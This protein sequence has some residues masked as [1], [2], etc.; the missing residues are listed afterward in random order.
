VSTPLQT[1][2]ICP[3]LVGRDMYLDALPNLLDGARRGEG[4]TLLISGEAGIGKSRL[5]RA[6]CELAQARGVVIIHGH[7]FE[8]DSSLA[9]GPLI[10]ALR[11]CEAKTKQDAIREALK[12]S[13]GELARLVPQLASHS[14]ESGVAVSPALDAETEKRRLF[15]ALMRFFFAC[16]ESAPLLLVFEDLHWCDEVS[17][18]FLAQLAQRLAGQPVL[19]ALSYRA[20]EAQPTLRHLLAELDRTRTAIEWPLAPLD[21]VQVGA[22]L[23]A[24]FGQPNGMPGDVLDAIYAPTEGNP[25]FVEEMLKAL[26]VAG[27][28]VFAD[29]AWS[30]RETAGLRIPRSV[31]DTVERRTGELSAPARE[32][33]RIAAVVGQRFDF[34][35]L[36]ALT[37]Y[38]E[39]EVLLLA[40][41]LIT[42]QLVI[43][44]SAEQF[45]FRHAL[46]RRAVYGELLARERRALHR[47]VA[48][49]LERLYEQSS[50]G[51]LGELAHHMFEAGMWR[52]ALDYARRAGDQSLTLYAP[53]AALDH[54]A[55]AFAAAEHLSQVPDMSLLLGRGKAYG[56]LGEFAPALADNERA[57]EVARSAGD[58]VGEWRALNAIGFLWVAR[59]YA[60]AGEF[61]RA[62]LETAQ[63]LG[64]EK[65]RA[66]SLNWRAN[67]LVNTGK[68]EE[69]VALHREALGWFEG[70]GD[71]SG[72]AQTYDLLGMA[73]GI[74]GDTIGAVEA[75]SKAI[76]LLGQLGDT[77]ILASSRTTRAAFGN[78]HLLDPVYSAL[79]TREECERDVLEARR[80]ARQI[81]SRSA[82]GFAAFTSC[83]TSFAFGDFANG[84]ARGREALRVAQEAE[85]TQWIVAAQHALALGYGLFLLP[86]PALA[87]AEVALTSAQAMGSTWWTGNAIATRGAALLA[88]GAR[89]DLDVSLL[90]FLP[91]EHAP[92]N[93]PER[94]IRLVWG[95]LLLARGDGDAALAVADDLLATAPGNGHGQ[96][97]PRLLLLRGEALAGVG[98]EGEA[99]TALESA[100]LGAQLRHDPHSE[101]RV[102][103]ALA[104]LHFRCGRRAEAEREAALA[105]TCIDSLAATVDDV[106]LR[107]RFASAALGQLPRQLKSA[108]AQTVG[109][110]K[111][112]RAAIGGLT[113]REREVATLVARG[114]ANRAIADELVVSERTVESHVT[115]ILGKLGFSSRAQIA[116]WATR[117]DSAARQDSSTPRNS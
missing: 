78:P 62:A 84:V 1:S 96:P 9:Y 113:Q 90:A 82:E 54:Y 103:A 61:F 93:L 87:Y 46:T 15:E 73:S 10:D 68:A 106:D 56:L 97:I 43:E 86:E 59:D 17:L 2:F 13:R 75:V 70:L 58:R 66:H 36:R 72:I 26:V 23:R 32:A 14:A 47:R 49:T 4:A 74:Y 35:L 8:H 41:E 80:L 29:G 33:L 16:A 110:E 25:F 98:R 102:R 64:D 63:A 22:M 30:R 50:E 69:G 112:M 55:R 107:Q 91:P 5:L 83:T 48:T 88:G 27:D 52:E 12:S 60:Q 109:D 21:E 6:I 34:D 95:R 28:L 7:C 99:Q 92:Q 117:Q 40:K 116:A 94:R 114:L 79:R 115:N 85:H 71:R 38:E 76:P 3:A 37:G 18:E 65:L 31:Q 101:W 44:V 67:W 11:A 19:V 57:L 20:D 45:G 24:I 53:A 89:D 100:L 42:A 105:H 39:A 104:A 81:G 108:K 77:V 111:A 51:H